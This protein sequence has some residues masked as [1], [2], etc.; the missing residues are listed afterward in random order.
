[1]AETRTL[2]CTKCHAGYASMGVVPKTCPSCRKDTIWTTLRPYQ[3][4][5]NDRRFLSSL[6]IA[7]TDD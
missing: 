6:R 2:W 7:Q 1:M 3:L 5:V 4:S